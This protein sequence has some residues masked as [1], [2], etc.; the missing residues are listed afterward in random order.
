MEGPTPV[1][2]LIHAATMVTA[3]IYLCIRLS[4]MFEY[5]SLAL[6]LIMFIGTFS[7]FSSG[8]IGLIQDDV[9]KVIAYSTSTQ[10]GYMFL[11]CGMSQ[12]D[13][14]F[15]HLVNH[16]FF[17]ALLFLS[18]GVLIHIYQTQDLRKMMGVRVLSSFLY[19][20]LLIGTFASDGFFF[21]SSVESKDIIL[22]FAGYSFVISA[23]FCQ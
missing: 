12:Y 10:L 18:G 22:E 4:F 21:F 11:M 17:K 20:M 16:A 1:S 8:I 3:G 2:A 15:F 14:A 5:C 23:S 13:L 9:K 7:A 19:A 6:N